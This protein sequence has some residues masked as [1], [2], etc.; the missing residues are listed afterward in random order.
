MESGSA[1][2]RMTVV[3]TRITQGNAV[4]CPQLRGEDGTITVVSYLAP[5]IPIGTRVKVTGFYAYVTSCRGRVLK[6][7]E[8][9]V[10]DQP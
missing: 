3:G 2:Q 9:A 6:A 7:E 5:A 4:D 8:V 10:L 1:G